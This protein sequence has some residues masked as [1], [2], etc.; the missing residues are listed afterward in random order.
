MPKKWSPVVLSLTFW[1]AAAGPF[2]GCAAATESTSAV[3]SNTT[4][5]KDASRHWGAD[6]IAWAVTSGIVDGYEDG[7]FRPDQSVSEP[8]FLAMLLRAYPN[9]L[10]PSASKGAAWFEPYYLYADKQKWPVLHNTDPS[11]YNRGSV[12][13]LIAATQK[14]PLP[15]NDSIRYLLDQGLSQGKS[16]AT[17]EGYRAGDKLSRAESV[18]FIRNLKRQSFALPSSSPDSQTATEQAS[19]AAV[20]VKG[21]A[22]GDSADSVVGKL[23]EP[24]RKDA[25]EYG[26]QWYI[27][28]GNY[29]DYVQV[30][31]ADGKVAALYSPSANWT[32]E[33]GIAD[34]SAKADVEQQYGSPLQYIMKGNTRFMMNYG[35][36]EYGTYEI[37]GSYATFFYDLH[38]DQVVTGVQIVAK[39]AEQ[40]QT[41]FYSEGSDGLARAFERQSFDLA[42]AARVKLGLKAFAWDDAAAETARQH[43]ADMAANNYFDHTNLSGQSPFDRMKQNDIKYR[44]A[45][46]NIAAG[47]SSAIFAHHGWMNSEGHRK[48]LLGDTQRLGVGVSFGGKMKIYYTQNFYTP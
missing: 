6:A 44:T 24:A 2:A 14:G 12:A 13:R 47:Q 30:G 5:F 48:N 22:I 33:K 32:T 20:T 27:Y 45:A 21:I 28:N 40:A 7:T 4:G 37:G 10:V 9:T 16:A 8:E 23:G 34:G 1:L 42:N 35:N 36:G 17:V 29:S 41:S 31:I 19:G 15:L 3:A 43:S 25:G 38:R 46:E 11:R 18:Q 39:A 26:V